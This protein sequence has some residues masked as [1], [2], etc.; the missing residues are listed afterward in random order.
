[1]TSLVVGGAV[2]A[3]LLLGYLGYALLFPER[4]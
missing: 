3:L 1:M 2:L 4:F